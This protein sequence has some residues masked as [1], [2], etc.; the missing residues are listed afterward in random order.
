MRKFVSKLSGKNL[1]FITTLAAKLDSTPHAEKCIRNM[2][3]LCSKN[4]N[5]IDGVLVRGR[6]SDEL[7]EKLIN[8]L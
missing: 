5:F 8:F 3:N 2:K 7:Q 1:Y 6:V 4:N